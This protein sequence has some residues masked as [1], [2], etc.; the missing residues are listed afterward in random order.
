MHVHY[1][2]AY[3][4]RIGDLVIPDNGL[5]R[6]VTAHRLEG[7]PARAVVEYAG[8]PGRCTCYPA[9]LRILIRSER[10]HNTQPQCT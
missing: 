1:V 6:R 2:P 7:T 4:L 8:I 10:P 5:P 9:T 3:D